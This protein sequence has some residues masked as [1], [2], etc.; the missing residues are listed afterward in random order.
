MN[1]LDANIYITP[2][3]NL[4]QNLDPI[5]LPIEP[6]LKPH[7]SFPSE[8]PVNSQSFV[9]QNVP[10]Y[11]IVRSANEKNETSN[12]TNQFNYKSVLSKRTFSQSSPLIVKKKYTNPIKL[13]YTTEKLELKIQKDQEIGRGYY[14]KV[15]KANL[16]VSSEETREVVF[17]KFINKTEDQIAK[18]EKHILTRLNTEYPK[19][20][21]G[22]AHCMGICQW[23]KNSSPKK[24]FVFPYYNGKTLKDAQNLTR[25]ETLVI[26][27][28]IAYGLQALH[29]TGI[30]HNDLT[31]DNICLQ[32]DITTS[33]VIA[34]YITDFGISID[35]NDPTESRVICANCKSSSP[36]LFLEVLS[37]SG[38]I[39]KKSDIFS[40]GKILLTLIQD[41]KDEL[42]SLI[43]NAFNEIP[44]ERPSLKKLIEVLEKLNTNE[45]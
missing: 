19:G 12:Y 30:I 35:L 41:K 33:K 45:S 42:G 28:D 39:T 9:T 18:R 4:N 37:P 16:R 26:A 5:I 10:R 22:L 15:N 38:T 43:Q 25:K 8:S 7:L 24:G 6:H 11:P 2:N 21:R 40:L 20:H 44:C 31:P 1:D 32:R 36:E 14:K 3:Q 34:A 27:L 23:S 29:R 17:A 13:R